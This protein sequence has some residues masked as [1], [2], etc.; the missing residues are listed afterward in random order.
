MRSKVL[1]T[2]EQYFIRFNTNIPFD[3]LWQNQQFQEV[4]S[5]VSE[6]GLTVREE[7][8]NASS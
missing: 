8:L 6:L 4:L 7:D 5:D 2:G 1:G 3:Q